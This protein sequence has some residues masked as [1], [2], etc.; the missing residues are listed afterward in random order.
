MKL[1][2][3]EFLKKPNEKFFFGHS[4]ETLPKEEII[5]EL[6]K[7][8]FLAIQADFPKKILS[9][10]MW[11]QLRRY[12]RKTATQL[13]EKEFLVKKM[14]LWSDE[15]KVF[16]LFELNTLTLPKTKKVLGPPITD[17]EN[18][19]KFLEK[20]RKII[21]GPK[22]ENGRVTIEIER[23]ETS[24]KKILEKFIKLCLIDETEGIQICLKNAKVLPES[25]IIKHYTGNFAEHLTKYLQGKE[26]FE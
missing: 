12:L 15:E 17:T 19:K 18:T 20:K 8:E 13:E 25:E 26:A 6:K 14:D 22:E 9:D 2:A 23:E 10:L 16:F 21:S 24:A 11:G 3:K 4:V 5:K 1:A 7:R